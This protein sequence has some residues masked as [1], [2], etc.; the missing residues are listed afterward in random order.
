MNFETRG[1]KITKRREEGGKTGESSFDCG[2]VEAMKKHSQRSK[3]KRDGEGSG[4]GAERAPTTK[5]RKWSRNLDTA[6]NVVGSQE[7]L[8]V[9]L[10][11]T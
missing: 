7:S 8:L 11:E 6:W 1:V 5:G 3:C 10:R 2:V 4:T 9:E